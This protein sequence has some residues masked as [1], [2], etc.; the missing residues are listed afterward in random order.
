MPISEWQ[1]RPRL[2]KVQRYSEETL[3]ATIER[4][5][6]ELG[7]IPL[8]ADFSEWRER[9]LKRSRTPDLLLPTDSPYRSRYGTWKR[10]LAHFGFSEE[11]VTARRNQGRDGS[12]E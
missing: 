4:C 1:R 3:R 6:D 9:E 2:R 10:A 8:I 11:T 12:S 5:V 7:R